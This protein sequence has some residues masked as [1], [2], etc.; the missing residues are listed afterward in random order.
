MGKEPAS[1][2]HFF[3][4]PL[5]VKKFYRSRYATFLVR[6]SMLSAVLYM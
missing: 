4:D 6:L 1:D 5:P 2:P 3:I